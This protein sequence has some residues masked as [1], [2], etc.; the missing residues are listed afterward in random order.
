MNQSP[1]KDDFRDI[2]SVFA[3]R[4]RGAQGGAPSPEEYPEVP[5]FM[6]VPR[7]TAPQYRAAYS[8]DPLR[9]AH[10][11]QMQQPPVKKRRKRHRFLRL[12]LRLAVIL[13]VLILLAVLGS[14]LLAK[15]PETASPIGTR[16]EDCA[17]ILLCGTDEDGVR[18][19]TMLL[20]YLDRGA[21][22]IR[23]LSLPRDTMVNRENPVPKLNGAYG[24]NGMGEK[25]MNV[26]MDYVRDLIGYRPDGYMLIDLDCFEELVDRMGGVEYDVPMDMFYSDPTQDL[27]IDLKAGAQHL[28]GKEAM[29]LVRYRSGYPMADLDRV[30]VQRS[31]LSA[32][33]DQWTSPGKFFRLPGALLLLMKHTQTDLSYRNLCWIALT[34][35]KC[36]TGGL[37]SDTLPGEAAWVNG[38]AYYVEDREKTAALINEK[39]NPYE[40][41]ITPDDLHP[42]G[43]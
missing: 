20:L 29:W 33:M 17:A 34:V 7:P 32:A 12:L 38:G 9:R 5:A 26:L 3:R 43:Y 42:Y 41:E 27:Y 39:Y 15:Q 10:E 13:L 30:K 14:V 35:A 36:G 1:R 16:R 8:T 19:D 6:N 31:F 2:E 40:K 11:E 25:G 23:L 24:A 4:D 37:E 28:G 18:T 22:Q 21:R